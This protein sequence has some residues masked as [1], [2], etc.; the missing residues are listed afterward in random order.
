MGSTSPP[1]C[2]KI[3]KLLELGFKVPYIISHFFFF[4]LGRVRE[5]FTHCQFLFCHL[6]LFGNIP[7]EV[8]ERISLQYEGYL[9]LVIK[10]TS[11]LIGT[12][13][14]I[15]VLVVTQNFRFAITFIPGDQDD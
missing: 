9:L 5:G 10:G 6:C 12:F 1:L 2:S 7:Q 8:R 13:F 15:S 11:V 4:K 3:I 14:T